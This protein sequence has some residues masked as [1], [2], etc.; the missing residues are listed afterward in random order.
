MDGKG[1]RAR[2]NPELT[3]WMM[4]WDDG[5][6]TDP[7]IS[8]TRPEQL[9]ACGNGVVTLQAQYALRILLARPGVPA[10]R[11]AREVVAA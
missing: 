10:I 2:L 11:A 6:V 5:W 7:A 4:G 3:E 1:E 8:L 9:K